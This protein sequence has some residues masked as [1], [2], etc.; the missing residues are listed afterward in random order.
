MSH[1]ASPLPL[2]VSLPLPLCLSLQSVHIHIDWGRE[3]TNGW[4]PAPWPL[5]LWRLKRKGLQVSQCGAG[6]EGDRGVIN[7]SIN[8]ERRKTRGKKNKACGPTGWSQHLAVGGAYQTAHS[9]FFFFFFFTS[10]HSC[11]SGQTRA[12]STHY[13][14]FCVLLLV[15]K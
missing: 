2:S 5:S 3:E 10:L 1:T 11:L 12:V 14:F 9:F 4:I 15:A 13:F 7:D 8:A 6:G